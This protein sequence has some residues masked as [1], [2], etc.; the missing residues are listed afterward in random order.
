MKIAITDANIFIDLIH[1]EMHDEL[2]AAELEIHTSLSVY[3]ELNA[4]QQKIVSMYIG[5]QKLTIHTS[6]PSN[7]PK[8]IQENRSLSASD[9]SVFA[10]AIELNAFILTGDGLLRKIAAT[11][12]IEVH[13]MIW[14]LDRFLEMKLI[15]KKKANTQLKHLMAYNRRLPIEDC[16]KRLAEWS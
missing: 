12:R 16:E 7:I 5:Q 8:A 2:F 6:E 13:G 4:S 9:K 10:L 1:I 11:Q 14:L 15:T 3:D